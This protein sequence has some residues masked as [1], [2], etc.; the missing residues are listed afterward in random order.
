MM[1]QKTQP[2]LEMTASVEEQILRFDIAMGN[3]LRKYAT[4]VRSPFL[5]K[6]CHGIFYNQ[7]LCATFSNPKSWLNNFAALH[8]LI[9]T[10]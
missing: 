9:A 6:Y 10:F 1:N 4:P 3:A 7:Q 5:N 8:P 2:H